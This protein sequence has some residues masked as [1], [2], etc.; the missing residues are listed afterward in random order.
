MET[1]AE[2]GREEWSTISKS[3]RFSLGAEN[4]G[5]VNASRENREINN[6]GREKMKF[7]LSLFIQVDH[8]QDLTTIPG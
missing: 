4:H 7:P 8:M 2:S 6:W 5:R 3:T 1:I